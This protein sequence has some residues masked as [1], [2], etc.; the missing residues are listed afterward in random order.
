MMVITQQFPEVLLL[1][2][3]SHFRY[4]IFAVQHPNFRRKASDVCPSVHIWFDFASCPPYIGATAPGIAG[5]YQAYYVVTGPSAGE[6]E[7]SNTAVPCDWRP[8]CPPLIE[9]RVWEE[10]GRHVGHNGLA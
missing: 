5:Y 1:E 4:C 8:N 2:V 7:P 6:S 9:G 3:E 10:D